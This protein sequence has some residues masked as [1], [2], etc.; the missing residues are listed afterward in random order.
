MKIS[1][2]AIFYTFDDNN[3]IGIILGL[4]S[5]GWLPFKGR[6]EN[7]ETYEQTAI[8]EIYEETCGLIKINEI[9]LEH[10]FTTKQKIYHI[11]L[12]K[13]PYDFIYDFNNKIYLETRNEFKEKQDVKF[14]KLSE[15]FNNNKIHQLSKVSIQF[16]LNRLFDLNKIHRGN[17]LSISTI[18]NDSSYYKNIFK[19][20]Y[21]MCETKNKKIKN[22]YCDINSFYN[23]NISYIYNSCNN[24]LID[25]NKYVENIN[26]IDIS[27]ENIDSIENINIIENTEN[28]INKNIDSSN[29]INIENTKNIENNINIE[30]KKDKDDNWFRPLYISNKKYIDYKTN[31]IIF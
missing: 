1:C 15:C 2:G 18:K 3:N 26:S 4:E 16:Y 25:E 7:N 20:Y 13:V 9:K 17:I 28:I 5:L 19:K 6:N 8:R 27:I 10:K 24:N 22:K 11:G 30:N 12:I 23:D 14:F 29:I 31:M 21:K